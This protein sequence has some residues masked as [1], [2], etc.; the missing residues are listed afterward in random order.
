M[1]M[2]VREKP[3]KHSIDAKAINER[4]KLGIQCEKTTR[5]VNRD[6]TQPHDESE[7]ASP[8]RWWITARLEVAEEDNEQC[9]EY[10]YHGS[11]KY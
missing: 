9:C 6:N 8:D 2:G 5:G 11:C 4:S 3:E 1:Q 10:E 7:V